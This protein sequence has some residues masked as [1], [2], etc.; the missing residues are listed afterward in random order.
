M[1]AL[2]P[3]DALF[4]LGE[5]RRKPMHVAGLQLFRPPADAG[6]DFISELWESALEFDVPEKPFNQR[7]V[8]RPTG[9]YRDDDP[10]FDIHHHFRHSALPKPGRIRELLALVSRLHGTHCDRSRPLWEES[11]IEGLNDGRFALYTKIHHSLVDG[12][13]AMRLGHQALSP[14]PLEIN[15]PP[16]WAQKRQPRA[17]DSNG[18][19]SPAG[20][21]VTSLYENIK[22]GYRLLPA[23]GRGLRDIFRDVEHNTANARPFHAPVTMFNVPICSSRRF[24]AQ[25]YSL[26]RMKKLAK[27]CN[28]TINDIALGV[29]AGALRDY[30]IANNALPDKPLIAMVPVSVRAAD[31]PEDG[32]QVAAILVNLATHIGDPGDRLRHIMESAQF[33]KNRL[34]SMSRLEQIAYTA[35]TL[36]PTPISMALGIDRVRPPF[37]LVISNVP[38]PKTSLYWNGAKL[39]EMYPLSIPYDGQA[40]NI[41]LTSYEDQVGFGFTACRQAVPSLQRLLDYS[42]TALSDLETSLFERI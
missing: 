42:E 29:C 16:I 19:T 17:V 27:A 6:D 25:S 22:G 2:S 3:T 26:D 40:M 9:W 7:M 14:D 8:L 12:M 38:G 13:A 24:A 11:L 39:E 10:H 37:N 23:A 1:K 5:D 20:N 21:P 18:A 34:R 36:G 15:R 28:G 41:T 30:L 32:N 35:A 31:S 4:L 33:A